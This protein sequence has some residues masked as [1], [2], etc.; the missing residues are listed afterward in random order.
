MISLADILDAH[1]R[2]ATHIHRTPVMSSQGI[3]TLV[4]ASLYFKCE[5][6]QKV[7]AFKARGAANAVFGLTDEAARRGVV[8]HS[9]G[10][11]GAA[12]AWAARK[13]GIAAT[14]VVPE[15]A[16]KPKLA[17]IAAYGAT[18]VMCAPTTAA[19]EATVAELIARHG[20]ELIH[21]FD[22]DRVIAGQGTAAVELLQDYPDLDIVVA[23]LGGGGLL[24]GTAVAARGLRPQILVYGGEP[25]GADDG[26]RSF[27][28]RQRVTEQTP[29][30][31]CD[32]LRTV[33]SQR[34]FETILQN[35]EGI[36]VVSEAGV[37]TAMRLMWERL[38]LLVEP[39]SAPPLAAIME[40]RIEVRGKRVG[41]IIS[42]GNLDLD[43][44]PW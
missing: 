1:R 27:M 16:P 22:D 7:G 43:K 35:V 14:V 20:F 37:V 33:L 28:K 23:P 19:R 17:A 41:I 40:G 4:G 24:S 21:P 32:G 11:H 10:N 42:G 15:N 9:S 25:E 36:G 8:T 29:D 44:L 2:I 38:K 12:L 5:N 18:V 30:T 6:L 26:Y 39:S 3:D 34:T 13:R 31:L